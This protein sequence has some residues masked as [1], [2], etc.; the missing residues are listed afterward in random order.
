MGA[1]AKDAVGNGERG[2][3]GAG[4]AESG[5]DDE[6]EAGSKMGELATERGKGGFRWGGDPIKGGIKWGGEPIFGLR[7]WN[8]GG[9]RT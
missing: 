1:I 6:W 2:I 4:K 7:D 5:N 3:S 9:V 8:P